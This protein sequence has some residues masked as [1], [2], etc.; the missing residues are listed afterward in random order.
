[1]LPLAAAAQISIVHTAPP[2]LEKSAIASLVFRAP[3]VQQDQVVEAYLMYSFDIDAEKK[4]KPAVYKDGEFIVEIDLSSS[5]AGALQYAFYLEMAGGSIMSFPEQDPQN[6]PVSVALTDPQVTSKQREG[7]AGKVDF[8]VLSPEPGGSVNP[9]DMVVAI[10]LFYK[11]GD[12]A[13]ENFQ[14]KINGK[15]VTSEADVTPYLISWVPKEV[16]AEGNI[17]VELSM[18]NDK[19]RMISLVN[20]KSKVSKK[21]QADKDASASKGMVVGNG[22]LA[23]RNQS[24]AGNSQDIY[25]G[26]FSLNARYGSTRFAANGLATSLENNRLQ[27]QNRYG[28]ELYLGKWFEVQGGHIYPTLNNLILSGQRVYGVNAGLYLFNRNIGFQAMA[29][30]INRKVANLYTPVQYREQYTVLSTG[31]TLKDAATGAPV[32]NRSFELGGQANGFGTYTRKLYAGRFN[33]GNGRLFGFGISAMKVEDDTTSIL[34]INRFNQVPVSLLSGLNT[35]QR[36]RLAANPD[37]LS[38]TAPAPQAKG[39]F[40]VASD[41]VINAH[42]GRF[43]LAADGAVSLLNDDIGPG[44]LNQQRAADLGFDIDEDIADILDQI[45]TLIIINE[46]MKA[47]PIKFEDNGDGTFETVP[48]VPM[49]I[50]AGQATLS[51]NYFGNNISA[52]YMWMGPEFT[53]L[54]NTAVRRDI[55]GFSVNDRIRLFRNRVYITGG[56]DQFSDNLLGT[57]EATTTTTSYRGGLGWYP[58]KSH[59]PR[60]NLNYRFQ[61]RD[62][63]FRAENFL[64]DAA[65]RSRAVRS[66]RS[67]TA[68]S[69]ALLPNARFSD[70][71]Q[72]SATITQQIKL[73]GTIQDLTAGYTL[74]DTRDR[75]FFYGNFYSDIY[76]FGLTSRW[77]KLP[78][79]TTANVTMNNSKALS[80]LNT[81][82]IMG[83]SL[84]AELLLFDGKVQINTDVALATNKVTN[85]ELAISDNNTADEV[86]DDYFVPNYDNKTVTESLSYIMNASARY[87]INRYHAFAVLFNYTQVENKLATGVIPNDQILQARYILNF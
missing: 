83:Y 55:A 5:T 79:K 3:G 64:L 21:V 41:L 53:P 1:M 69:S 61:N 33:I 17:S 70:T 28:A 65:L 26:N 58:F 87:N 46:N 29:G 20:F 7:R 19:G 30:E 68:D 40:M 43:R 77:G 45:S 14:L 22:E 47:L 76:T 52:Q 10:T 31:D 80:G 11:E 6:N 48:F 8:T 82:N 36:A 71:Y 56:Y 18:K 51:L 85:I 49:G 42:K 86:L 15:D 66:V 78:L 57:L 63:G 2:N 39:N 4:R 9:E 84:G 50:F 72:Y 35:D 38:I 73:L 67:V 27:P 16:P 44:V 25:R 81:V 34:N 74:I 59:L 12:A 37:S 62:N 75:E 32:V 60:I 13:A 54:S 23:A 24:I